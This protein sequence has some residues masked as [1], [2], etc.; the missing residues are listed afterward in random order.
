MYATLDTKCTFPMYRP[1]VHYSLSYLIP[2]CP[3]VYTLS[4][5]HHI[6]PIPLIHHVSLAFT[7]YSILP[8]HTLPYHTLNYFTLPLLKLDRNDSWQKRLVLLGQID[9]PSGDKADKTRRK[10]LMAEDL[11]TFRH[12]VVLVTRDFCPRPGAIWGAVL[13]FISCVWIPKIHF[14]LSIIH[15][16]ISIIHFWISK[17]ELRISQNNYGYPNFFG[18]PKMY[19]RIST[20]RFLNIDN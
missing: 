7:Y 1:V 15:F 4:P 20:N 8:Y 14:R 19:L 6:L 13:L 10:W 5:Y 18:Y 16:W 11:P 3:L 2:S 9:L 17:N 12:Q